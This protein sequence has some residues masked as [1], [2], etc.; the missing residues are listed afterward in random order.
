M[1]KNITLS[2]EEVLIRKAREKATSQ[3]K[4]L[5]VLFR[6]WLKQYV[7]GDDLKGDFDQLMKRLSYVQVGGKKFS[8][9]QL[10]ERR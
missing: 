6:D 5:N 1:N 3:R 10:N 2:A 7:H 8:R 9:E 4:S